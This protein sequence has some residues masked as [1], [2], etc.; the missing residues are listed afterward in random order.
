M[1]RD[2]AGAGRKASGA[3]R[4]TLHFKL[5]TEDVLLWRSRRFTAK[6]RTLELRAVRRR[7]FR[8]WHEDACAPMYARA[9]QP[10]LPPDAFAHRQQEQNRLAMQQAEQAR[11]QREQLMREREVMLIKQARDAQKPQ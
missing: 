6:A 1:Q 11:Q 3:P 5:D 4:F 10:G 8:A 2:G 9:Y 7:K